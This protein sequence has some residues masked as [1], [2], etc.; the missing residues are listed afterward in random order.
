MRAFNAGLEISQLL[1]VHQWPDAESTPLAEHPY[2]PNRATSEEQSR[3][4][5]DGARNRTRHKLASAVQN[6]RIA[7]PQNWNH[8]YDIPSAVR[9]DHIRPCERAKPRPPPPLSRPLGNA[10]AQT[11]HRG[12]L[13]IGEF[14]GTAAGHET[15]LYRRDVRVRLNAR[16]R[17]E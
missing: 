3:H 1:A 8:S 16:T 12:F 7:W 9:R 5:P 15:A 10:P 6:R 17:P 14:F 4:T 11:G 13:H 2:A